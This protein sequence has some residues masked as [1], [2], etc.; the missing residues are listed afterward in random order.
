MNNVI[1]CP[2]CHRSVIYEESLLHTCN[3]IIVDIVYKWQVSSDISGMGKVIIV[4]GKDGTLYRITPKPISDENLQSDE[5]DENRRRLDRTG[6]GVLLHNRLI[7][8]SAA[9]RLKQLN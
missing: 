4:E 3:S 1:I 6:K 9:V 8:M 7:F 2:R 5:D